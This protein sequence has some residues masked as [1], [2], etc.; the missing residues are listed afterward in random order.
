MAGIFIDFSVL[1]AVYWYIVGTQKILAKGI[2][3]L[4]QYPPP[5]VM[6]FLSWC[7]SGKWVFFSYK[8]REQGW[9]DDS[10]VRNKHYSCRW[11]EFGSQPPVA[12]AGGDV[13]PSSGFL[14]HYSHLCTP[15]HMQTSHSH[16]HT[17][18]C[19]KIISKSEK[20]IV[21]LLHLARGLHK[22]I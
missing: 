18:I 9:R 4:I 13:M 22:R 14:G 10:E 1:I 5:S 15:I 3:I 21:I 6:C 20:T 7:C 16:T 12:L 19:L 11:P 8:G 2:K 17:Q